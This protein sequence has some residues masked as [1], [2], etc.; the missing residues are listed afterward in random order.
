MRQGVATAFDPE[1]R[2][3]ETL[4]PFLAP[5]IIFMAAVFVMPLLFVVYAS[6]VG[7][8]GPTLAFYEQ[9]FTGPLYQRVIE[10]SVE[11]SLMATLCAL[12]AGYPVAYHLARRSLRARTLLAILVLLPFWTSILVKSFAFAVLLGHG[13]IVN[14]L[15]A[16]LGLAPVP[17]LYNRTG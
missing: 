1:L 8:H 3:E 14:R 11:V 17:L 4:I 5:A 16:G 12:L 6:V 13:G 10:S 9:V 2:T 15:I 7:S